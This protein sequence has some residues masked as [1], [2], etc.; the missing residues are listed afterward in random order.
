[1]DSFEKQSGEE[2]SISID[3]SDVLGDGETISTKTVEA[4]LH[5]VS[6][7]STIIDS[8][9]ISGETVI[10]KIKDGTENNYKITVEI[11]TS[12][13]NIYEEDILMKVREI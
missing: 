11:I 2:Y 12:I 3:F 6:V 9:V 1:M 13:G 5:D 7:T 10:I 8:S 4:T